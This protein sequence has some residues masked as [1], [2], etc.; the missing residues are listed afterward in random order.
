MLLFE[1]HRYSP[2]V[3]FTYC[4]TEEIARCYHMEV[5]T[6]LHRQ[7]SSCAVSNFPEQSRPLYRYCMSSHG[8]IKQEFYLK[9]NASAFAV[10]CAHHEEVLWYRAWRTTS[11]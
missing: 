10:L 1:A 5:V 3:A 9:Y 2:V 4:N 11:L 7:F 6:L 8:E